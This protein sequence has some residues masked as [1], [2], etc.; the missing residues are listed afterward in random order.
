MPGV[1]GQSWS[2]S[3]ELSQHDSE[4]GGSPEHPLPFQH[5][6]VEAWGP[7]PAVLPGIRSGSAPEQGLPL[8]VALPGPHELESGEQKQGSHPAASQSADGTETNIRGLHLFTSCSHPLPCLVPTCWGRIPA[9]PG[10]RRVLPGRRGTAAGALL[11]AATSCTRWLVTTGVCRL[12]GAGLGDCLGRGSTQ[13]IKVGGLAGSRGWGQLCQGAGANGVRG[14]CGPPEL[15]AAGWHGGARKG[16]GDG[17]PG[18]GL[19]PQEPHDAPRGRAGGLGVQVPAALGRSISLGAGAACGLGRGSCLSSAPPELEGASSSPTRSFL[20]T[21]RSGGLCCPGGVHEGFS[22]R[23]GG[24][25]APADSSE[26][27][28]STQAASSSSSS[29][30]GAAPLGRGRQQ[31][32]GCSLC[33]ARGRRPGALPGQ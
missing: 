17:P 8:P 1:K 7:F 5:H 18:A 30:W 22:Q 29:P 28:S 4:Q 15:L 20:G 21:A 10:N 23:A 11:A 2:T 9:G 14:T 19:E 31:P 27:S 12:P 32:G 16:C 26:P 33:P 25:P 24:G 6:P 13:L 3:P